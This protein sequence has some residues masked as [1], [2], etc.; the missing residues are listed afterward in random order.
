MRAIRLRALFAA[1]ALLVPHASPASEEACVACDKKVVVSG[2]FNHARAWGSSVIQGAPRRGDDAFREE[3][4]GTNFTVTVSGLVPGKYLVQI[5]EVE[6]DF[7]NP[8]E[9]S[10]DIECGDQLLATNLDIYAAA[11]GTG[12]VCFV[13]STVDLSG[14]A[15]GGPLV[16]VFSGNT[17]AAKFKSIEIKD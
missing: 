8:G 11:G 1:A 17:N 15:A 13:T 5:G 7:A 6:V 12:K 9:R 2:D 3:I 14:N 10:F 4:Y 16:L